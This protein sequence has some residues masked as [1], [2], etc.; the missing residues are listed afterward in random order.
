MP[1]PCST[2]AWGPTYG[3]GSSAAPRRALAS[4]ATGEWTSRWSGSGCSTPRSSRTVSTPAGPVSCSARRPW[5]RRVMAG[6]LRGMVAAVAAGARLAAAV[7]MALSPFSLFGPVREVEPGRGIYLDAAVL[8][9]GALG[10]I[11]VLGGAAAVI[12]Y[13]Q[14][15][16]R[17]AARDHSGDR[18]PAAARAVVAARLPVSGVEGLRLAL[19]PGRGRTAGP[20][21]SI[22]A[23]GR[24]WP[25]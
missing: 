4:P 10:L 19:E 5:P 17:L 21:R 1:P 13:R 25:T 6:G 22:I 11:L 7:A 3:S 2:F 15:P 9:L 14:A 24:R 23:G 12:A 16:H 8:G 20:V 18:K